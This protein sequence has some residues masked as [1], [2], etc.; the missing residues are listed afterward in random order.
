[1]PIRYFKVLLRGV[2]RRR[3]FLLTVAH[4]LS[5]RGSNFS[6][7]IKSFDCDLMKWQILR[8]MDSLNSSDS[9]FM[10]RYSQS[11]SQPTLYASAYA[12]MTKSMLGDLT[13]LDTQKIVD[14][15]GYFDSFQ[16][17][18]DGLFYDPVV[19]NE[20]YADSDWWGA[21]HLALHMIS[22]YTDLG[23]RPRYPFKFLESYYDKETMWRW[24]DGYNWSSA[25]IGDGD[26]DN[27]I[28]NIGCLLQYQR[29]AWGDER[30]GLA[31]EHLKTYLREKINPK[32]EMWGDFSPEEKHQRSRAVQFAYHL[33]PI[34]F[35]D[36]EFE[37]DADLIVQTVLRT[38]NRFG[39]FGV[40]PNSS[41]CEDIDSIDLLIRLHPFVSVALQKQINVALNKAFSWVLLNQAQDGGFVFRLN[42]TFVYGHEQTTSLSGEGAMLATWFRTLSIVYLVKFFGAP[43]KFTLTRTPGYEF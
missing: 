19:Q 7:D 13:G 10:Y 26:P 41:A 29:D 8:F 1:M 15:V 20:I 12:C 4:I 24:L 33:F 5:K 43:C 27:K 28:M 16:E 34:F 32:T 22:A 38:Q 39:G 23:A 30:A 3:N 11:S 37:F 36:G 25:A 35:Y 6:F 40:Q 14:W 17:Q 31:V 42:Q 2:S 18:R 9:P 21:R